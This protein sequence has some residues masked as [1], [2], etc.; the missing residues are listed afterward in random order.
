MKLQEFV[1]I[2]DQDGIVASDFVK[3][4]GK[5]IF[6][7]DEF[8][9]ILLKKK[10]ELKTWYKLTTLGWI[11]A[12]EKRRI[13]CKEKTYFNNMLPVYSNFSEYMRGGCHF[14]GNKRIPWEEWKDLAKEQVDILKILVEKNQLKSFRRTKIY[15]GFRKKYS[16]RIDLLK[17]KGYLSDVDFM[18]YP[19]GL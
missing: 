17:Q 8:L 16:D 12:L 18:S 7:T 4:K 2:L 9:L 5:D 6:K 14:F 15:R 11:I 10:M 13:F 3:K 1:D 19:S